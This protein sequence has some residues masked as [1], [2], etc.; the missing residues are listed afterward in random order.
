MFSE[1]RNY[2][3]E[4]KSIVAAEQE[5]V[6]N[7][8]RDLREKSID[9]L[10]N[11]ETEEINYK[12][13]K[14]I[15]LLA[16]FGTAPLLHK[17]DKWWCKIPDEQFCSFNEKFRKRRRKIFVPSVDTKGNQLEIR[18]SGSVDPGI[19]N[20]IDIVPPRSQ[21][22]RTLRIYKDGKTHYWYLIAIAG[23]GFPVTMT[24]TPRA[25][26]LRRLVHSLNN[27]EI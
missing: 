19:A 22:D 5:E 9:L 18:S 14:I 16:S 2:E 17:I 10:N 24:Y 7:L 4:V 21:E 13:S 3:L 6:S 20:Y 15:C 25:Q 12:T 27:V 8:C 26:E 11:P 1:N 23:R